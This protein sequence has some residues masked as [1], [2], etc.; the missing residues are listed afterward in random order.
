VTTRFYNINGQPVTAAQYGEYMADLFA[1]GYTL[2]APKQEEPLYKWA[3]A[4]KVLHPSHK[5]GQR[6]V[7]E[8]DKEWSSRFHKR[9]IPCCLNCL[10]DGYEDEPDAFQS[11]RR[12]EPDQMVDE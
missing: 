12:A 5:W 4:D 8:R 7:F 11:C 2:Q 3:T 1:Q 9:M 6:P 10:V